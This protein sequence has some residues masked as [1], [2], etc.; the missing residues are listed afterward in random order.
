M[1]LSFL[2]ASA[3]C[4]LLLFQAGAMAQTNTPDNVQDVLQKQGYT[5][6]RVVP[7]SFI[8]NAKDKDGNPVVMS[9]SPNS[10]TAVTVVGAPASDD[11]AAA[12]TN[13]DE[14]PNGEGAKFVSISNNDELSSNL[15]GLDVYNNSNQNVGQIKDVALSPHGRTDAFILSVG[16]FLGLGTHYVAINPAIIK[17]SY[18]ESDKKWHATMNATTDQLKA[19]PEFKYNDRWNASKS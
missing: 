11:S 7:R 2:T 8:V 13:S 3:A 1:R 16:G 17:V 18:N 4:A 10:I 12:H 15:I 5:D 14:S 19:A 6:I 9:V